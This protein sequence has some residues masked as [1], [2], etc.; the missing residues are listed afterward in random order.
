MDGTNRGEAERWLYTANKL[1][2]ARDLH[3]ARSFAIRA[4]ES[5]PRFEATELLIA[6]I[7]TLLAGEARIKEHLDYYAVLQII[8]YTQNIEYIADQYRRLAILLDPNRN[9]FAY[10]AHAF[11]LV[12]DA[13]SIFS[14]PHKKAIYD[15]Q[16]HFLT[17]PPPPQQQQQQQQ[18]IQPPPQQQ[19]QFFQP[20]SPPPPQQPQ[21][22]QP[23]H[24]QVQVNHNQSHNQRKNPRSTNEDRVIYEEQNNE[25][26]YDNADEPTGPR[27]RPE[28]AVDR[29]GGTDGGSFWT[30]CPYCF[31]MFEYPKVYE[32]CTLRCQNCRRGFHGLAV[33]APPELSEDDGGKDGGSFCSF[34]Y[35]PLGFTGNFKDISGSTSEWNPISP[36][37]PCPGNSK[38]NAR[39]G[40]VSYYDHDTCAAFA[41]LSDET[42]DDTDDDDWRNGNGT[43]GKKTSRR[44]RRRR[45]TFGGGAGDERRPVDR[46]R[47]VVQNGNAGND[48]GGDSDN[49]VDGEAVDAASAPRMLSNVEASKRAVLSGSRRRGAG[50]LGKLDLNVEFSN[51]VEEAAAAGMKE[52]NVNGTGNAE[53]N[54]EGIGFFEG[55]DEFLNSLPILNVVAD[56]KVKCH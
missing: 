53:D 22:I 16:L 40:P 7:D 10:A 50:N 26:S 18:P 33:R 46:P 23:P 4:R 37:F 15:E 43:S 52:G 24:P 17:Q 13:W 20:P 9:P 48:N 31:G 27:P 45:R 21:Q 55:L 19:Q 2:S 3:G 36:L 47:R 54:I 29:Q 12:H 34:G 51:E 42:E 39:K 8:R 35:F 5:D 41:E 1:L 25:P 28:P 11:S 30:A 6:V 38:K 32:D 14:N 49:V 44:R 56:D